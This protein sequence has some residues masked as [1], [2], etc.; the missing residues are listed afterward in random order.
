[1]RIHNTHVCEAQ[2]ERDAFEVK[3]LLTNVACVSDVG[4]ACCC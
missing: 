1:M 4:C 2:R 3:L